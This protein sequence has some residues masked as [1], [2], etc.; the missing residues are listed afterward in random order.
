MPSDLTG[1]FGNKVL[2]WLAN[3][4]D[5]PARPSHLYIAL[6]NGNPKTSGVEVG[7]TINS[8]TPR[9]E[10][11]FAALASGN[12]HLLTSNA[13]VDFGNAEASAP[14]S[15]VALFDDPDPGEGN[16]YSS[17]AVNGG[18]IT[19]AA[20]SSVKFPSGQIQ[21]NIGSDT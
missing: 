5:M 10:C 1:Y 16:M 4:A 2:R 19:P 15:H 17:K 6:F 9:I 20:N 12:G 8:S 18:P 7:A 21:F 3:Q 11:T 13:V 14:I